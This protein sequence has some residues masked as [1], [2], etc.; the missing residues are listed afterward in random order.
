MCLAKCVNRVFLPADIK[1]RKWRHFANI[2]KSAKIVSKSGTFS[3]TFSA[4][5]CAA[6]QALF[7]IQVCQ[8]LFPA[9]VFYAF[10]QAFVPTSVFHAFHQALFPKL[11]F[12]AVCQALYPRSL[13]HAFPPGSSSI[14]SFPCISLGNNSKINFPRNSPDTFSNRARLYLRESKR[15]IFQQ[16]KITFFL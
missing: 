7:L 15:A 11:V 2:R 10:L 14:I 1:A 9:P 8:A 16:K 6:C 3:V 5:F 4:V 12:H 13:L